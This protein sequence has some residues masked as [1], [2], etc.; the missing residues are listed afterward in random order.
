M[1]TSELKSGRVAFEHGQDF[2]SSLARVCRDNGVW[3]GHIRCSLTTSPWPA[4]TAFRRS[5]DQQGLEAGLIG[6]LIPLVPMFG[7]WVI[8]LA[9]FRLS[10]FVIGLVFTQHSATGLRKKSWTSC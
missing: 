10:D 9:L 6:H 5:R 1:N 8:G 2:T 4:S 7:V 3:Q